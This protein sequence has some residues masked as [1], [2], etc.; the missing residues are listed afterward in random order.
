MYDGLN[1]KFYL[2]TQMNTTCVYKIVVIVGLLFCLSESAISR[3]R[4]EFFS[5]RNIMRH[6]E[7][8]I[9]QKYGIVFSAMASKSDK[10]QIATQIGAT[11]IPGKIIGAVV[12]NINNQAIGA[13]YLATRAASAPNKFIGFMTENPFDTPAIR[14]EAKFQHNEKHINNINNFIV[15]HIDNPNL[16]NNELKE[17]SREIHNM[18]ME[19][20]KLQ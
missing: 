4:N 18:E 11:I 15:D 14:N 2:K 16:S 10:V 8:T 9:Q 12:K 13:T 19:N 5:H 6:T 3:G 20:A 17:L 7:P 1:K